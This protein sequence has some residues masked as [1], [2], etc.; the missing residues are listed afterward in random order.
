MNGEQRRRAYARTK[1]N[2]YQ[3]RGLLVP[4]PCQRCGSDI[5]V[6]K[7]HANYDR[8]LDVEWVCRGCHRSRHRFDAVIAENG[9]GL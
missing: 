6:E 7:H 9:L 1:A 2:V 4:R 8:P 3:M 5:N